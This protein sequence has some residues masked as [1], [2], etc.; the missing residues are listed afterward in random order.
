M[1]AC[2][3]IPYQAKSS[4]CCYSNGM[5]LRALLRRPENRPVIRFW[6]LVVVLLSRAYH[7]LS[8]RNRNP[9]PGDGPAI[10]VCNHISGLDPIL[11][12]AASSRL[13]IWMMAKEY[14]D[15]KAL[16]WFF[17]L[18]K[19]I[20]VQRSGRDTAATRAAL[21]TLQNG[22]VLGV[23]PEGK[24]AV[25]SALLPFQIGVALLAIKSGAPVYPAYIDG[26]TRGMEMLP[27][28]L[29]PNQIRLRFGPAVQFDRSDTSKEALTTATAAIRQ[30]VE[31]LRAK[32]IQLQS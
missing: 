20:P 17:R 3:V 23:F 26:T 21:R 8:V 11:L 19:A 1:L 16:G 6:H 9:L 32:E 29:R 28:V 22:G 15:L 31:T 4:A 14:Y 2:W 7:Q 12:Q 24:I 5:G 13:I 18:A 27:A 30:A 10:L 25:D